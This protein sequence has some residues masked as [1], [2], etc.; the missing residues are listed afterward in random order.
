MRI[1]KVTIKNF[2]CL[3]PEEITINWED[4]VVLVG[5]NNTGKSSIL[6][7]IDI[8]FSNKKTIP[9]RFFRNIEKVIE[10]SGDISDILPVEIIIEFTELTDKD[11]KHR[12]I[13]NRLT[14]EDN[15]VLRK[16]FEYKEGENSDRVKYFTYAELQAIK[17]LNKTAKWKEV[18]NKFPKSEIAK[19]KKAENKMSPDEF[20]EL[21][22]EVVEKRPEKISSSG[23]YDWMPNPGGWQSNIDSIFDNN[24]EVVF[25]QAVHEAKVE[26]IGSGSAFNKLFE[27]LVSQEISDSEAINKF[28]ESLSDVLSLYQQKKDGKHNIPIIGTLEK[29]LSKKIERIITARIMIKAKPPEEKM[30]SQQILPTPFLVVDDGYPTTIEDQGHGL[31]RVLILALLETLADHETKSVRD[32]GPRNILMIEEPELYMH[33]QMERKMQDA[34]YSIA[35]DGDFQVICTTHSPVF[36]DMADKHRSIVI[37]EKDRDRI[38]KKQVDEE[39]FEGVGFQEQKDRLRM[40]L[41]FDPTVNELFFARRVVLVEGDSEIAAFR[42]AAKLLDIDKHKVKDTTLIN[43]RGKR[44]MPAFIRVLN[45][46]DK[47]F[48]VIHDKDGENGFNKTIDRLAKEKKLGQVKI[49]KNK[50]EE[51]LGL[52]EYPK[53]KPIRAMLKVQQLHKKK[54]LIGKL[55]KDVDFVFGTDISRTRQRAQRRIPK[56]KK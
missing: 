31:Q 26:G 37:L 41:S 29:E 6:Y 27:L 13:H 25:V 8:F 10:K 14:Q 28:R 42:E 9:A 7:A 47:E 45:H 49:I 33:P 1:K 56:A 55:G 38:V 5:E 43:C 34:L 18:L 32:I 16:V 24:V 36:L 11:K 53:D 40:I 12:G 15:W 17:D 2:K 48:F 21:L 51:I 23:K 3:G 54:E 19:G 20:L 50:L 46:F 22:N 4:I 52:R 35:R 30:V 44:T 39:I